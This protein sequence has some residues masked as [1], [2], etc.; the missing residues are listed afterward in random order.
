MTVEEISKITN[1]EII[2]D[3]T[4]N[5]KDLSFMHDAKEGDLVLATE[6]K[7][8]KQAL[9]TP[10][11]VILTNKIY[12][13]TDKILLVS[14]HANNAFIDLLEYLYKPNV[15]PTEEISSSA[16]ISSSSKIGVNTI[17]G[18][19]AE[20][21][22]NVLIYPNCYIGADC[23]IGDNSIVY[24][25]VTIYDRCVL[26]KN[27][28]LHAGVVVGADGFGYEPSPTG[29]RKLPHIGYVEISDNVEI[30]A[31]TCID[32]AKLGK[33]FIGVGTK[34]DNLCQIAHN[35]YIG[36]FTVICGQTGIA[37]SSTIMD[38]CVIGAQ[39]G[40]ADHVVIENNCVIGAKSGISKLA[41][42]GSVLMGNPSHPVEKAR[43]IE[44][45]KG[46]L[47]ETH[48]ELKDMK[49]KLDKIED[50]LKGVIKKI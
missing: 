35:D 15:F 5:V 12:E 17:I 36:N 24:P 45:I 27:V 7:Y 43:R 19:R 10:C 2:G 18:E 37:G 30:G 46:R 3:K 48:I 34:V 6:E 20:I 41:P 42:A 49:K 22:E 38:Q 1:T 39:V 33:T 31:N 23:K 9:K 26:G 14:E 44:A 4:F 25:N 8:F 40:V 29:L 32:R 21:G 50:D 13:E 11:S 28:I 47:P 16:K